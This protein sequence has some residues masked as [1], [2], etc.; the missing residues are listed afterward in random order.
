M[1]V[2]AVECPAC[3]GLGVAPGD[4][5]Y[6]CRSCYG[7]G[8]ETLGGEPGADDLVLWLAA[9]PELAAEVIDRLR[10]ATGGPLPPADCAGGGR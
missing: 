9:R 10:T 6:T 3:S 4:G 8:C 2:V 7:S 5:G 1:I